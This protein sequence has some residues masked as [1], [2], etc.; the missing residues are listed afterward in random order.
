MPVQPRLRGNPMDTAS[1]VLGLFAGLTA[2]V[3]IWLFGRTSLLRQRAEAERDL[4]TLRERAAM[5]EAQAA[6][7]RAAR[8]GVEQRLADQQREVRLL[9]AREAEL[10]ATLASERDA[11]QQ[12]L[13]LLENARVALADA[14]KALSA[15]ALRS[16]NQSFLELA[17]AALEKFQEQARGDLSR[18][19]QAIDELVKPVRETLEKFD[20]HVGEIELSRLDA[21]SRL[22]E[23]VLSLR[24]TQEQLQKETVTL[25][26]A[27]GSPQSRGRWGE[28]TLRRVVEL[29]G[30]Q[31]YCDVD[32]QVN[33]PGEEGRLRPDLVVRLPGGRC[34]AVDA[35]APLNAY[36]EALSA[37]DDAGRRTKMGENALR[38]REHIKALAAKSY[39]E[40]LS[41]AP[42]F[43]VL[44]LPGESFY[45]AALEADPTL[46]EV[47]VESRVVLATPTTLIALLKAVAFGW[48]QEALADNAT[49]ISELG[50]ELYKRLADMTG[51]FE[52]L[53][54]RLEKAT[55]SY[56]KAMGSL[57][58]RVLV[59]ARRF[60]ELQAAPTDQRIEVLEPVKTMPR[61]G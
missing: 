13:A 34:V 47:G 55:E 21:Y 4:A 2:T 11:A 50:R 7:L 23:Q 8:E 41:P 36:V 60:E 1:L 39:W 28:L 16:N 12:K 40:R 18:R 42:E 59:S 17:R 30:M 54:Q 27:L 20:R 6:E 9:A 37:A 53:G 15:D 32:E 35:K 29:A 22:T 25:A 58:S 51:H 48:R 31:K 33:L 49:R 10:G 56:N 24:T 5:L 19:Q 26:R 38:I 57:E 45:S 43:V 52:D 61:K 14:F 46:I 44:C 3:V